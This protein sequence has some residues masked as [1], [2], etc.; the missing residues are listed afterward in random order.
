MIF[1]MNA[2]V[3]ASMAF[4]AECHTADPRG[5]TTYPTREECEDMVYMYNN[6]QFQRTTEPLDASGQPAKT[7]TYYCRLVSGK[8]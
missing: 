4:G 6:E 2:V 8:G 3:C 7:W 5:G 1:L